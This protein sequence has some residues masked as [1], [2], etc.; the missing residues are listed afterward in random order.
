VTAVN[1]R[2]LESG[3]RLG[4]EDFEDAVQHASAEAHGLDVI[5]TRNIGDFAN[6]R[7]EVLAPG[8]FIKKHQEIFENLAL[9]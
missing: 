2:V 8:D 3:L 5:V 1:Q 4:F 6:A 9:D 7:L